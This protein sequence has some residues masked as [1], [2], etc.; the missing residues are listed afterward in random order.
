MAYIQLGLFFNDK[1]GLK[2]VRIEHNDTGL[3]DDSKL[4]ERVAFTLLKAIRINEDSVKVQDLLNEL[5]IER[6]E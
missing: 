5:G 2:S 1:L 6:S 3:P 4:L